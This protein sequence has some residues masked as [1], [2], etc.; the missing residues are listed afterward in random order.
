MLEEKEVLILLVEDNE[1]NQ[2][3]F[4]MQ[5]SAL[6]YSIAI[7]DDGRKALELW[8]Q[9]SFDLIL[10]DCYMP[11]MDGF[12][13][14][15]SVRKLESTTGTHI[16]IIAVTANAMSEEQ[17]KCFDSGMNDCLIKPIEIDDLDRAMTKWLSVSSSQLLN[18]ASGQVTELVSD[19]NNPPVNQQVLARLTG[20]DPELCKQLLVKFRD[21]SIS[22]IGELAVALEEA[23]F[24]EINA[25]AHKLKSSAKTVGAEL[26]A[27]LCASMEQSEKGRNVDNPKLMASQL[28]DEFERIT[29]YIDQLV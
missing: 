2:Q 6:G 21:A 10:T 25:L 18:E 22:I 8:Q 13:L 5:L 23:R 19:E 9:Q 17:E 14:A 7:A 24:D 1:V 26:L 16:P 3:V 28:S 15:R 12:E 4:D 29:R 11:E 27:E 20:A